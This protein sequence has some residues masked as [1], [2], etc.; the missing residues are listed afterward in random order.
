MD[1]DNLPA[2]PRSIGPA[3]FN[4]WPNGDHGW[5]APPTQ[6]CIGSRCAA[7]SPWDSKRK[8]GGCGLTAAGSS[9]GIE[10]AGQTFADSASD[11]A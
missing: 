2:C 8:T 3:T 11:N 1:D 7:W 4:V 9:E 5:E 10:Y 6:P